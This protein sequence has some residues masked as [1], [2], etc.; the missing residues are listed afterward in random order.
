[1]A[2]SASESMAARLAEITANIDAYIE[3]RAAE[4]AGARVAAVERQAA[5]LKARHAAELQRSQEAVEK[6]RREIEPLARHWERCPEAL[7]DRAAR[8]EIDAGYDERLLL[9]AAGMVIEAQRVDQNWIQRH[10]RVGFVKAGRLLELLE[11]AGVIGPLPA[12]RAGQRQV[13][14]PREQRE[15]ALARLRE[16]LG[17]EGGRPGTA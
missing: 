12:T 14:I 13:L 8:A 11:E 9:D 17:G 1:M 6:L 3:A 5:E 4:I 2:E 7:P 10:V 16:R 15:A